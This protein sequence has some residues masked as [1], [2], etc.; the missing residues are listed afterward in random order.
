MRSRYTTIRKVGWENLLNGTSGAVEVFPL[1]NEEMSSCH[2]GL[3]GQMRYRGG[4]ERQITQSWCKISLSNWSRWEMVKIKTNQGKRWYY[5]SALNWLKGI[6]F[7]CSVWLLVT[8]DCDL[9]SRT[10]PY[11][12]SVSPW[13]ESCGTLNI[14]SH[15]WTP[16]WLWREKPHSSVSGLCPQELDNPLYSLSFGSCT[17]VVLPDVYFHLFLI[18]LL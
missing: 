15:H 7:F 2:L 9:C 6:T 16:G 11:I 1:P 12:L 4:F 14:I 13:C 18:K 3:Y 8:S 17:V 10:I 5:H